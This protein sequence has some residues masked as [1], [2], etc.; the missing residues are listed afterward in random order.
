MDRSFERRIEALERMQST[1]RDT[2][3]S[4][5]SYYL[6]YASYPRVLVTAFRNDDLV[7][8]AGRIATNP[9]RMGWQCQ[10]IAD[11]LQE[12]AG[13]GDVFIDDAEIAA[14]RMLLDLGWIGFGY[15][16]DQVAPHH[17]PPAWQALLSHGASH[18]LYVTDR[19]RYYAVYATGRTLDAA[20]RVASWRIGAPM[21]TLD[22]VAAWLANARPLAL[23]MAMIEAIGPIRASALMARHY[24]YEL[25]QLMRADGDE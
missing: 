16:F 18:D 8:S 20:I 10:W 5:R 6:P 17:Q 2:P 15:R 9:K 13:W 7:A 3:L 24:G 25:A 11:V 21:T 14:A 1:Q 22:Q 19:A 4:N 12:S 23:T